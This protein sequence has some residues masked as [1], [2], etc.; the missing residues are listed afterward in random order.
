MV[1]YFENGLPRFLRVQVDEIREG[2]GVTRGLGQHPVP[3]RRDA[4]VNGDC[5]GCLLHDNELSFTA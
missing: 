5:M 2:T 3:R 1:R 4:I